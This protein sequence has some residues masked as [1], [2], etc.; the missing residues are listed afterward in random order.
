LSEMHSPDTD[1]LEIKTCPSYRRSCKRLRLQ[2]A[3]VAI[4]AGTCV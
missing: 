1:P 3:L 4:G 2:R